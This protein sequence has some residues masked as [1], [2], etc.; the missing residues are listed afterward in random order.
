MTLTLSD[1]CTEN[2]Y[3]Y[4]THMGHKWDTKRYKYMA[5]DHSFLFFHGLKNKGFWNKR[6]FRMGQNSTFDYQKKILAFYHFC[7]G[8]RLTS[9]LISLARSLCSLE[10]QR[11]QRKIFLF[12][13]YEWRGSLPH[14]FSPYFFRTLFT[15]SPRLR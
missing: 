3:T 1:D 14:Q 9:F 6:D 4:G 12:I 10:P 15:I 5:F 11:T 8:Q 7:P 13:L 2:S